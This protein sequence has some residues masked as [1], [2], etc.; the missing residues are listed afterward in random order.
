MG[1]DDITRY[2]DAPPTQIRSEK[3]VLLERTCLNPVCQMH[4]G[5]GGAQTW[6]WYPSSD[7]TPP[8][9]QAG[10]S[11]G[12]VKNGH[13]ME[14]YHEGAGLKVVLRAAG[15]APQHTPHRYGEGQVRSKGTARD[16]GSQHKAKG[17]DLC[18]YG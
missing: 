7:N 12:R 6:A 15:P 14:Q 3:G 10:T 13:P 4:F 17:F 5:G 1:D 2:R 11:E 8:P 9:P 16:G 18:G